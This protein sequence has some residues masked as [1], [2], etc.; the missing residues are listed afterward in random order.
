VDCGLR[1]DGLVGDQSEIRNPKSAIR[2]P[3]MR[4]IA[5]TGLVW[6]FAAACGDEVGVTGV[7][8]GSTV[9]NL[10]FQLTLV[11][12]PQGVVSG[13]GIVANGIT[14]TPTNAAGAHAHPALSLTIT[15]PQANLAPINFLGTFNGSMSSVRGIL[16]GSGFL[17]DTLVLNRTTPA[18]AASITAP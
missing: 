4:R 1:I 7:W 8:T 12:T 3:L 5:F 14:N 11:E 9:S 10:G 17:R 18:P 6:L 16:N 13:V 2:V 15:F